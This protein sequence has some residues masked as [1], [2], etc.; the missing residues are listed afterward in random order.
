MKL[1]IT[2]AELQS[3]VARQIDHLFMLRDEEKDILE[4]GVK[5]ALKRCEFCFSHSSNKYYHRDGQVYFN[6]FHSGQYSIFLYYLASSVFRLDAAHRTLCDRIYYLNKALNSLDLLYEVTMPDIFFLDHPVGSVMGRADYGDFFSFSQGCT[7]G[8]NKGIYPK[9]G[10]N[11]RMMSGS[12]VLGDCTI[13]DNVILSA[14][15]YIKDVDIPSCS[16]VFGTSPNHII[17][18][19]DEAYFKRP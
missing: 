3:L 4:R 5:E 6:P 13:G 11:V 14:N 18:R 7:V 19:K 17:K 9:F 16:I 12:K 10:K 1:E 8:N 15:S 2:E